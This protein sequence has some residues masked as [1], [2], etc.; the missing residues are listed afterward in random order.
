MI[1]SEQSALC[2]V[3][4]C[5]LMICGYFGVYDGE[6]IDTTV[7]EEHIPV[8]S[9][10]IIALYVRM[11][12][13]H[14]YPLKGS[15]NWEEAIND[16]VPTCSFS[17][18]LHQNERPPI[19]STVHIGL[20]TIDNL[21]FSGYIQKVTQTYIGGT[22]AE[23]NTTYNYSCNC[24]GYGHVLI[25]RNVTQ[26]YK[27]MYAG[28]IV[29]KLVQQ[30][31]A[32]IGYHI[33]GQVQYISK[34]AIL[35]GEIHQGD[36]I[37][38]KKFEN[39]DYMTA[40]QYLAE[41]SDY[42]FYV[43]EYRKLN[44][45]PKWNKE[46]PFTLSN[47]WTYSL[48]WKFPQNNYSD[49]S[50]S[51]DGSQIVNQVVLHGTKLYSKQ[52]VYDR[53][54]RIDITDL[55]Y[56]P[57][58]Y[59]GCS[60]YIELKQKTFFTE[61][62]IYEVDHILAYWTKIEPDPNA[63]WKKIKKT[64]GHIWASPQSSVGALGASV[65]TITDQESWTP[66]TNKYSWKPRPE[67]TEKTEDTQETDED[68]NL[69]E[70]APAVEDTTEYDWQ[71]SFDSN[72]VEFVG[73]DEDIQFEYVQIVYQQL[74]KHDYKM[75]DWNSVTTCATLDGTDGIYES[76]YEDREVKTQALANQYMKTVSTQSAQPRIECSY[77]HFVRGLQLLSERLRAGMYQVVQVRGE[78]LQL[79]VSSVSYSIK[80]IANNPIFQMN[81]T[82]STREYNLSRIIQKTLGKRR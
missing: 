74:K 16:S 19:G 57:G 66:R 69:L 45:I 41:E 56:I 33:N 58:E 81:V 67:D 13:T 77:T 8:N 23:E 36:R 59:E 1:I 37:E 73:C 47:P 26:S 52:T 82:L 61:F 7:P 44:F 2:G 15:L 64:Y 80:A 60:Y 65:T 20:G 78:S 46:A 70:I 79:S 12:N 17:L 35:G 9:E 3:A 49:M 51:H 28:N 22:D 75:T 34:N 18:A 43:D 30:L 27:D 39:E 63:P 71:I 32:K 10:Q 6:S 24:V 76:H 40:I 72:Q 42:V 11:N 54:S 50:I 62:R 5:G 21:L 38:S 4:Q 29:Q 53:K 55:P 48:N 68:G 31:S 14:I 25:R